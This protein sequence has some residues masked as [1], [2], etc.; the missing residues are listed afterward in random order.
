MAVRRPDSLP[1]VRTLLALGANPSLQEPDAAPPLLYAVQTNNMP[2]LQTLL[3]APKPAYPN[4]PA[5]NGTFIGWTPLIAAARLGNANAVAAMLLHIDS[6]AFA[7]LRQQPLPSYQASKRRLGVDETDELLSRRQ[8]LLHHRDLFGRSLMH[9]A[10]SPVDPQSSTGVLS[11]LLALGG[12]VN[13]RDEQQRTPLM[14]AVM[15]GLVPCVKLLLA[16]GADVHATNIVGRTAVHVCASWQDTKVGEIMALLLQ[17]GANPD[18][19]DRSLSTP[20][21]VAASLG[22]AGHVTSLIR[23]GANLHVQNSSGTTPL[24]YGAR[25]L[26]PRFF[27]TTKALLSAGAPVNLAN[28][29]G[30]TPLH[31][32]VANAI[33]SAVAQLIAHGADPNMRIHATGMTA[34]HL[35]AFTM[36]SVN[37]RHLLSAGALVNAVDGIGKTPLSLALGSKQITQMLLDESADVQHASA[38]GNTPLH[39]ASLFAERA[40]TIP[41]LVKYG[42][43]V[44]GVNARQRTPLHLAALKN[45]VPTADA[46]IRAGADLTMV[47]DRGNTPAL[48]A[49]KFGHGHMAR[50][51]LRYEYNFDA[52]NHMGETMVHLAARHGALEIMEL[53]GPDLS[54]LVNHATAS[55]FTALHFAAT[56]HP[57]AITMSD[58]LLNAGA[59]VNACTARLQTPLMMATFHDNVELVSLLLERGADARLQDRNGHTALGLA[60][61]ARRPSVAAR[62][63]ELPVSLE[64]L[65]GGEEMLSNLLLS[66]VRHAQ[67]PALTRMLELGANPNSGTKENYTLLLCAVRNCVMPAILTLL[68][69][70]GDPSAKTHNGVDLFLVFCR[71][72]LGSD[73]AEYEKVIR[74]LGAARLLKL[75]E[76]HPTEMQLMPRRALVLLHK[77]AAEEGLTTLSQSPPTAAPASVPV[78]VSAAAQPRKLHRRDA[79]PHLQP[80]APATQPPKRSEQFKAP[81]RTAPALR[82]YSTLQAGAPSAV[83]T[84]SSLPLIRNPLL[85]QHQRK[86]IHT[87]IHRSPSLQLAS[88][89]ARNALLLLGRRL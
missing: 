71:A 42:A 22:F 45:L 34:L 43:N 21:H 75:G 57:L 19:Q 86:H 44:N 56:A 82:S 66:A 30:F 87:A 61:R 29:R 26:G 88:A 31:D 72:A 14:D 54:S 24:H 1:L 81:N 27:E 78:A 17:A 49:M 65:A 40:A 67:I 48:L 15:R 5:I 4:L 55:Q 16:A 28:K 69:H 39:F 36:V 8:R 35:A 38:V 11:M 33:P 13:A 74:A 50:A 70:G 10:V 63:L 51:L 68:E 83:A 60:I 9:A 18:A 47:D 2:L 25:Q 84:A 79:S 62:L 12:D 3:E 85:H 6:I 73:S 32:A 59:D 23:A 37:V 76:L 20:L 53:L 58:V 77:I 7:Q 52:S 89:V 80:T 41:L 46:L 64:E